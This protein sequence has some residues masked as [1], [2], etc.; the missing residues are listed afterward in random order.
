MKR[1]YLKSV[2][3]GLA[4]SLVAIALFCF[5]AGSGLEGFLMGFYMLAHPLIHPP[6]AWLWILVWAM[7]ALV[8]G[9]GF[10]W[11]FQRASADEPSDEPDPRTVL[12]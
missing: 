3:V 9:S 8:F 11:E 2:A 12:K 4:A 5:L 6:S 7:A 1:I 10:W